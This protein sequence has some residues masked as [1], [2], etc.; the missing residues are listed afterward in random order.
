LAILHCR[1]VLAQGPHLRLLLGVTASQTGVRWL[2][3]GKIKARHDQLP[4]VA[5]L[6]LGQFAFKEGELAGLKLTGRLRVLAP[7]FAFH[8]RHVDFVVMALF[9]EHQGKVG[10]GR[11]AGGVAHRHAIFADMAAEYHFIDTETPH[12]GLLLHEDFGQPGFPIVM[13]QF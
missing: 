10:T 13:A 1:G 11:A 3:C 2:H 7:H 6:S 4:L 8:K 9:A 12:T 5:L